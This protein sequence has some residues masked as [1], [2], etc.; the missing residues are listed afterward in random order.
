MPLRQSSPRQEA[1]S[2]ATAQASST[3]DTP[4]APAVAPA[5]APPPGK[6]AECGFQNEPS[7]RFCASCGSRLAPAERVPPTPVTNAP[8]REPPLS[9]VVLIALS[10]DGSEAGTFPLPQGTT[11]VGRST[12]EPF[13][14]DL[15]LSPRHAS[16]TP[17]G[18]RVLVRDEGS[19][20]GVFRKLAPDQPCPVAP[21]QVFRIGQELIR[22]D[23]LE[24]A[25]PDKDGVEPMG[26]PIEGYVGRIVMVLGRSSTGTAFPVPESGLNL[27][28]ERGEVLFSDDG[29]VSGLHCHLSY[30]DGTV[31]L[32]DLGSSNG[33]FLRIRDEAML[34]DGE[35]VLMGQQL[36]R[37]TVRGNA[38]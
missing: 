4:A 26:A 6:C 13:D 22:F 30:L 18:P 32:A 35:I 29:Y 23:A 17:Q 21:G 16:F 20:N 15:Y 33:T 14:H 3:G 28:R 1:R 36:F 34:G 9:G 38:G 27:G 12:G 25:G 11:V 24:P 31:L 2:L 5:A 19:L 10:P 37:I 8:P 7:N